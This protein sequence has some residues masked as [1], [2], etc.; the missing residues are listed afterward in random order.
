MTLKTRSFV[1]V[2]VLLI[3]C[4][5]TT[6]LYITPLRQERGYGIASPARNRQLPPSLKLLA[7]KK[8]K[9]NNKGVSSGGFGS[10]KSTSSTLLVVP[11]AAEKISL[12][13][14]WDLFA[15]ITGL[16]IRPLGDPTDEGY[17]DF[18]VV[19]VYVRCAKT[20]NCEDTGWFR[21]GKV[22][23]TDGTDTATA[24]TL[25]R[26][27]ILWTATH[28]RREIVALGKAGAAALEVGYTS[29]AIVYM[30]SEE[31]G[32]IDEDEAEL[33]RTAEK[34][35]LSPDLKKDTFGFRPDWNPP[36][37]TYKRRENAAMKKKR[38]ALEEIIDS[39][40]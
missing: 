1:R 35:S 9:K 36:G 18:Q 28:M 19:D 12:E 37:F 38:S 29:P 23:S 20:E 30:G 24:L 39:G 31:D 33:V 13:K 15:S 7:K 6:A 11:V 26:G 14:Q 22:C 16:E 17:V 32:P 8:S 25:Q 5:I 2:S 4:T 27:L 40:E 21:I 34:V 10:K 3:V